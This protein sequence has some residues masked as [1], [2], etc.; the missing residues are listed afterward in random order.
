MF[1]IIF[2]NTHPKSICSSE[3][4]K[5][6]YKLFW[7]FSYSFETVLYTIVR[8]FTFLKT[9]IISNNNSVK[10]F[11]LFIYSTYR[12]I[13]KMEEKKEIIFKTLYTS[14]KFYWI[15][16]FLFVSLSLLSEWFKLKNWNL[17]KRSSLLRQT[18]IE[19][20]TYNFKYLKY[21]REREN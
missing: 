19:E 11:G 18:C 2:P 13:I 10:Y 7:S 6:K 8:L 4:K 14:R 21:K 12:K 20:G 17:A 3:L 1:K 16:N 9:K 15:N 5:C